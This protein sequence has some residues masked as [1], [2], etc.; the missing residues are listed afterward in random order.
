MKHAFRW[1][2]VIIH[3]ILSFT[4]LFSRLNATARRLKMKD[5]TNVRT[6]RFG[7]W[8]LRPIRNLAHPK[9]CRLMRFCLILKGSA[10]VSYTSWLRVRHLVDP[11]GVWGE[12]YFPCFGREWRVCIPVVSWRRWVCVSDFC[13]CR[14]G[15]G[16]RH[17]VSGNNSR[18]MLRWPRFVI[19][20]ASCS[21]CT[22]S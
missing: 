18:K 13:G 9:H 16:G 7:H 19:G 17:T 12:S 5:L 22:S 1:L 14:G 21:D 20:S 4:T 6:N 11:F 2:I 3:W 10:R 8:R 15:G